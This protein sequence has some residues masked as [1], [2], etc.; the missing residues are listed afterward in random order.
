MSRERQLLKLESA[1]CSHGPG[2][3]I[4]G[5]NFFTVEPEAQE[6]DELAPLREHST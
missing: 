5:N 2:Y 4:F 6:A 1:G 3:F